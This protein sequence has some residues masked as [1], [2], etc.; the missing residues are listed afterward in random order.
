VSLKRPREA[1]CT[2][3]GLRTAVNNGSLGPIASDKAAGPGDQVWVRGQVPV[4]VRQAAAAAKS[5]EEGHGACTLELFDE[6]RTSDKLRNDD[7]VTRA[8]MRVDH[9]DRQRSRSETCFGR[10]IQPSTELTAK[11]IDV[12]VER[13]RSQADRRPESVD[14]PDAGGPFNKI[15]AAPTDPSLRT[16]SAPTVG[17]ALQDN[18]SLQPPYPP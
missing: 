17:R 13:Q 12:E 15:R 2:D 8:E 11:E 18:T 6:L 5:Y 7:V 1:L 3:R 14:L 9:R 10:L 16:W 4:V